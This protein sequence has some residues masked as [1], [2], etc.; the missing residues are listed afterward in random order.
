LRLIASIILK[1]ILWIPLMTDLKQAAQRL[2][3]LDGERTPGTW[4]GHESLSVIWLESDEL[5]SVQEFHIA[6]CDECGPASGPNNAAFVIHNANHAPALAR[7]YLAKCEEVERLKGQ[8]ELIGTGIP[9]FVEAL[10]GT[11]DQAG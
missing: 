10:G 6:E 8:L 2:I 5:G 7:A 4:E 11:D 1:A 3:E 9:S